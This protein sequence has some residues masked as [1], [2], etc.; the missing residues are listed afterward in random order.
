MTRSSDNRTGRKFPDNNRGRNAPVQPT[1][2][3]EI[4]HSAA[5]TPTLFS[6]PNNKFKKSARVD[7]MWGV[8]GRKGKGYDLHV[9]DA[10]RKARIT[11]PKIGPK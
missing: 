2:Q 10:S 4:E 5:Q 7:W 8:R 1:L 6:S 3:W 9:N 11:L